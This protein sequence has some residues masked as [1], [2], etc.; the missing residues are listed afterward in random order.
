MSKMKFV[1]LQID[2]VIND[3]E[4]AVLVS[5]D[6]NN[7]WIPLSN[8]KHDD[9]E[10]VHMGILEDTIHVTEWWAEREGLL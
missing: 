1:E 4:K 2:G 8:V 3:T 6:G 5:I 10:A 7:K 9:A